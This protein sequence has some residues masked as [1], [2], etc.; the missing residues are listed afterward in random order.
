MNMQDENVIAKKIVHIIWAHP[1]VDSLTAQ[2]V[3]GLKEVA[4]EKGLEVIELDLYRSNFDPVLREVDEP[5]WSNPD[6]VYGKEVYELLDAS[7]GSDLAFIVFPVWWYSMPAILK[8]YIDRV[9]NYG[10]TYGNGKSLP[11]KAIRWIALVGGAQSKFEAH[12]KDAH[13]KELLNDG[14]AKY[15]G[16]SDSEITFLYNT[17]AFEETID[18]K[19]VHYQGLINAA[20][21]ELH[22]LAE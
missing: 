9:W 17:I 22:L 5:D 13:M 12:K 6:K 4:L 15:C 10:L 14:I 19:A 18:D 2:V 21:R 16:V 11:Y 20:Q 7:A 3:T 1:R 8:G